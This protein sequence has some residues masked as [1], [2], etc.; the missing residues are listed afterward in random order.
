MPRRVLLVLLVLTAAT[1][2][3]LSNRPT[4]AVTYNW[5]SGTANWNYALHWSPFGIPGNSDTANVA[6]SDGVNRTITYDYTGA[7]VSLALLTVDLTGGTAGSTETLSMSANNLTADTEYIGYSGSG[8][9]NGSGTFNQSDGLNMITGAGNGFFLGINPTDSGVYNLSGSGS[10]VSNNFE[11][12][13]NSGTGTFNQTGGTNTLN[14][15]NY[16]Y[17]GELAGSKGTYNQTAGTTTI[18]GGILYIGVYAGATGTYNLSGTGALVVNFGEYI[19][20]GGMGFVNQTGGSNTILGGGTLYLGGSQGAIGSGS[21]S[22]S[23]TYT[24]NA[25]SLSISG[26]NEY[27]GYNFAGTFNQT[28]GSNSIGGGG[29]LFLGYNSGSTGLYTFSGGFLM[30]SQNEVIGN[31]GVGTFNQSGGSQTVTGAI[32]LGPNAGSSGTLTLTGGVMSTGNSLSVGG[33][34][35]GQGVLNVSG[36]AVLNIAGILLAWNNAGSAI[37]LSGGTIN[38]SSIELDAPSLLKWTSGT[39]NMTSGVT[40][41]SNP[42]VIGTSNT[43]SPFG[44][45]LILGGGQVLMVTGNETLGGVGPFSLEIGAGGAHY[46]TGTLTLSPTG[47]LTQDAG[48]SLCAATIMQAGGIVSGTLQNQGTFVYQSGLFNGRLLNQGTVSLGPSFT[49]G[50]GVENDAS[51]TLTAGQTLTANGQGLDNLGNFILSGGTISGAGPG[52]NE[53]S[54]TIQ[55]NGTINLPLANFGTLIPSGVL[56]L[57][58][59]VTNDGLVQGNGNLSGSF[60]NDVSGTVS[61]IAGNSL[62]IESNWTNAGLVTLQAASAR[63]GGGAINNTGAIQGSGNVG[64]AIANSG[65]IE[66]IGGTLV[67]SGMLLNPSG[68][69]IRVSTGNKLFVA[70]GLLASGGT[71]NLTGGTFD[72]NAQPLNNLGQIS[73]F[74][75]FATGGTGL[76]NNGSITFG[77]GVTT[78]NGSVTNE[79]G[80][81]IAVSQNP[82]IFTGL[83]TN[84]ANATFN[85]VNTTAIFAG[86]FVNNG[87]SNF[88]KAGAGTVEIDAAPT[89][90]NGS[91]LSVTTGTLRFNLI[92]GTPTIGTGVT[93]V[94]SGGATLELA[95]SVSALANGSDRVNILNNSNAPGVLV[96]GTNQQVG[97]I[98]GSGMTQVN[99]GGDLTANHIIQSAL[100]IGGTSKSPGIMTIDASDASGNQLASAAVLAAPIPSAPFDAG[101]HLVDPLGYSPSVDSLSASLPLVSGVE[102][103]AVPEPSTLLLFAVSA[104]LLAGAS[105]RR[106]RMR[107]IAYD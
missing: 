67:L 73:G 91:T 46:V 11:V 55:G 10:L 80:R 31:N 89:L 49:A 99:A 64:S 18:V 61:V 27:V 98:D 7:A 69:L 44:P 53:F 45:S 42:Q 38:V 26:G 37:N 77:G 43:R 3:L 29:S 1:V 85:A 34:A 72:N 32:L 4:L 105:F 60:S 101:A 88:L 39:L 68:G 93:A 8:G 56:A 47:T 57:N 33:I 58:G 82:A 92:S 81:T 19:G 71:I 96:S 21:G 51:M 13:G 30:V 6:N 54:G 106:H 24:L 22:A 17:V 35:G 86:G 36:N 75:T 62:A 102:P 63:L 87:N 15:G 97:N 41:D 103:A 65:T 16:F 59:G 104:L 5:N 28:G 70:H 100:V 66:P 79:G 40:W 2:A 20:S 90:N 12:V 74:G 94:V 48:G 83:V 14:N 25:G 78:V 9:S 76:D 23:G 107:T 84:N 52:V 50:N 95:G